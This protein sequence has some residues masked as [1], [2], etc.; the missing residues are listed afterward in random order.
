MVKMRASRLGPALT[1]LDRRTRA[2]AFICKPPSTTSSFPTKSSGRNRNVSFSRCFR[3]S[4]QGVH[5][6]D[7]SRRVQ[8]R[9]ASAY[10]GRK[11]E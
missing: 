11:S 8:Y 9:G 10:S 3:H 6:F 2:R 4:P 7:G 1:A 5:P